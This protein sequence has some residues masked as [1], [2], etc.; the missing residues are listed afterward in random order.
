[1]NWYR[2]NK[3]F[4]ALFALIALFGVLH[5]I[6]NPLRDS[7]RSA[8]RGMSAVAWIAA[9][10]V[11]STLD[12]VGG[13]SSRAALATENAT[14][15]QEVAR[16]ESLSLH[17]DVLR[18]ENTTL[19]GMLTLREA[20]TEGVAAPVL[21]NPAV[22]PFG[23]F[24]I[25]SGTEDGVAVGSYVL[26]APRVAIGRVVEVDTR[27]ALVELYSAPAKETEVMIDSIRSTY[28]GRG[29]GNGIVVIKRG[30]PVAEGDAAQLPGLPYAIGFVGHIQNNPEDPD[31]TLLVRIPANLPS[32]SFVYIVPE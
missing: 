19:R 25:G 18:S 24:I 27:T 13:F 26:S 32:L 29:D 23:T 11:G 9:H 8:A 5:S 4:V 14:L 6:D 31:T 1:M 7:V 30:V 28:R 17:N 3:S 20:H 21:S 2:R 15:K 22:S 12:G 16:L 10:E